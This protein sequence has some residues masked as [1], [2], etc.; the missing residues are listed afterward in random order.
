MDIRADKSRLDCPF[1]RKVGVG[2]NKSIN[3]PAK[4]I[5]IRIT[6]HAST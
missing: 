6:A 2:E 1:D 4:W 5:S 3:S